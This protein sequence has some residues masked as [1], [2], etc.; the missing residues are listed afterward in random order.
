MFL[1]L[2]LEPVQ[3]LTG[4]VCASGSCF[5]PALWNPLSFSQLC[6]LSDRLI[7]LGHSYTHSCLFQQFSTS[8]LT[9]IHTIVAKQGSA[10]ICTLSS[11]FQRNIF[12]HMDSVCKL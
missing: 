5:A 1:E 8:D 2:E 10:Y 3:D 9:E 4:V 11:S 7:R 12:F 6:L